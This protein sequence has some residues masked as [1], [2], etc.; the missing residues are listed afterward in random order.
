MGL[1]AAKI[2]RTQ[3]HEQALGGLTTSPRT[4]PVA[5]AMFA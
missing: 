3:I 2:C 5:M 1:H 4:P